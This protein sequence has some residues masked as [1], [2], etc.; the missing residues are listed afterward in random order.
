MEEPAKSPSEVSKPK[1]RGRKSKKEMEAAR[2]ASFA[3]P[4]PSTRHNRSKSPPMARNTSLEI[5]P[6]DEEIFNLVHERAKASL[7]QLTPLKNQ[8]CCACR[9]MSCLV[10]NSHGTTTTQLAPIP[11]TSQHKSQSS[12][13]TKQVHHSS[14]SKEAEADRP[15][16]NCPAKIEIGNYEIETWYSSLYPIEYASLHTVHICEYCL[17]YFKSSATLERH[18]VLV[19]GFFLL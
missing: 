6:E 15:L 18:K 11:S 8:V 16:M 1:K 9:V 3:S 7:N 2:L 4:P 10:V 14:N 5:T 17:K 19:V 13:A 12:K